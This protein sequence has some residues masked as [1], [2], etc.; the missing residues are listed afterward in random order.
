[1]QN[2]LRRGLAGALIAFVA[3]FGAFLRM[4]GAENV[5]NV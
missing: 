3:G 5:R 2:K 1:M 4:P